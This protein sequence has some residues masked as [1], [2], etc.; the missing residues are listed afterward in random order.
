LMVRY[1]GKKLAVL[2][3]NNAERFGVIGK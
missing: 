1:W 3:G 2:S